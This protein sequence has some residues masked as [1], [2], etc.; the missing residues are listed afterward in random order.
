LRA[1]TVLWL[2]VAFSPALSAQSV[3]NAATRPTQEEDIREAVI[4]YQIGQ[5]SR[6][7]PKN[8]SVDTDYAKQ[9]GADH[10]NLTVCFISIDGRDPSDE[11][12]KRFLDVPMAVKKLSRA[13][14]HFLISDRKTHEEG[15]I[16]AISEIRWQSD[17][18]V[19]VDGRFRTCSSCSW[20]QTYAVRLENG[21]WIVTSSKLAGMS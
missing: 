6:K 9:K 14:E 5:W 3:R 7:D 20:S 19:Q 17:S 16:L 15:I 2:V 1:L 11:F 18:L 10:P 4:R 12:L 8:K 13:M 21:K